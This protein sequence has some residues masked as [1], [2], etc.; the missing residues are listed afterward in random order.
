MRIQSQ[1]HKKTTKTPGI[2]HRLL[3]AMICFTLIA[4]AA[5][6]NAVIYS[7]G[8]EQVRAN[9]A[10]IS[11]TNAIMDQKISRLKEEQALKRAQ[12]AEADAVSAQAAALSAIRTNPTAGI[13]ASD[14]RC[15][16]DNP[17]SLTVVINKKHCFSPLE[18]EPADLTSFDG[19]LLRK[20]AADSLRQMSTAAIT[21]GTP[22]SLSSAYRSYENQHVTYQ[23][24]VRTN[25]SQAAADTVSARPGYSEH[26]TGL[27][28]DLKVGSCALEC[29]GGTSAYT[30]LKEHAAQYGFIERYPAGLTAITGYAPES[31]HWRYVGRETATDMQQKQLRTLEQYIGVEGGDY[32]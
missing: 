20:D 21:A 30:W 7:H 8:F 29:F 2:H 26:Q 24:W 3:T 6:I 9:E 28:A 15:Q 25:G 31:W 32:R 18:Y 5:L 23:H 12:A 14:P 1:R 10:Y 13:G 22:F 27:A 19:F 17:T 16:V 11:S 4:I